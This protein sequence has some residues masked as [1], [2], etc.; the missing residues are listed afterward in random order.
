VAE[1][2]EAMVHSSFNDGGSHSLGYGLHALW[3][4]IPRREAAGLPTP[5]RGTLT[6]ADMIP[7]KWPDPPR[8]PYQ[9]P[10][11]RLQIQTLDKYD[12]ELGQAYQAWTKARFGLRKGLTR[13]MQEL[14]L[15]GGD[16]VLRWPAPR[17]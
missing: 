7:E 6:P 9:T 5:R 13:R 8:F 10:N 15:S 1:I 3:Y 17:I 4:V 16:A 14:L 2:L 11:P 12:P